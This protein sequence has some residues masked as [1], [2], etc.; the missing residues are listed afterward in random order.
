MAIVYDI[1]DGR[2]SIGLKG[3]AAERVALVTG[4]TGDGHARLYNALSASGLPVPGEAHPS[5]PGL[6]LEALDAMPA[7]KSDNDVARVRLV[8]NPIAAIDTDL[9]ENLQRNNVGS[10]LR[11]VSVSVDRA[12]A[13]MIVKWLPYSTTEEQPGEAQITEA[14]ETKSFLRRLGYNPRLLVRA[15]VN[16]VNAGNW[17][18]SPGDPARTWLCT[19]IV[20]T[21]EGS[22][23]WETTFSFNYNAFTWD[24]EVVYKDPKT[25][26]LPDTNRIAP[27][28]LAQVLAAAVK[29]YQFY[30]TADF[31]DIPI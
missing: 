2:V 24:P 7:E 27:Y 26:H 5:I 21:T 18:K 28:S 23:V 11:T 19:G 10:S 3:P 15:F 9:P 4:M 30:E 25:G 6:Y 31:N 8:Y 12:G 17:S 14:E 16:K 20:G 22:G 29:R 1:I 13:P